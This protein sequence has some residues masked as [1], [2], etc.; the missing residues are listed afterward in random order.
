M[1]F[2][3]ASQTAPFYTTNTTYDE[4][5]SAGEIGLIRNLAVRNVISDYYTKSDNPALVERPLYREHIRGIIPIKVQII[6]GNT[7]LKI[8]QHVYKS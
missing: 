6:Y 1:A 5:T 4:L 7:V 3:Q 2:F 8:I